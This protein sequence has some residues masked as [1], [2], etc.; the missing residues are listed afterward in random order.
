MQAIFRRALFLL[1]TVLLIL[2]APVVAQG[3]QP[4]HRIVQPVDDLVRVTLH[5]NVHPLAQAAND[6]GAVGDSFPA[7]RIYL[8]LRHSAQQEAALNSYLQEAHTPGSSTYHHWLTPAAFGAQFG[9]NDE[10]I[11]TVTTWLQSKGF[12]VA[13]VNNGKTAIEFSGTAGQLRQAFHTE[14]HSYDV[15]GVMHVANNRDPEIPAALA[16]VVAGLSPLHDFRPTSQL[17]MLGKARY[18]R[19]THTLQPQWTVSGNPPLLM[20]APGDFAVQY[21]LNPL[22]NAGITGTGVTIGLIGA[23]N[24]LPD[25]IAAYRSFFGLPANTFNVIVDGIDPGPSDTVD[26]GNWAEGESIVDVEISG[27]VAPSATINLYTA[28]DTALQSGLLLAAQ[29]AVDDNVAAVLSTSYLECEQSLGLSGNQFFATLWEQAAA[30]GQTPFVSSGDTGSAAC[31]SQDENTATHGLA[32]NG[33]A[34]TPWNI[35]VGGTDFYYTSYAGTTAAQQTELATYWNMTGGSLW[36]PTTTVL[37]PIPEQ[38]WNDPFGLNLETAG[39]Y[40]AGESSIIG[41]GGG[42]SSCTTGTSAADGSFSTCT[43]GYAKPA[44]QSGTGVPADGVRDLPDVSLFAANGANYSSYPI[45]ISAYDCNSSGDYIAISLIGGTS[46]S[47]P[48]MAAIMALVN[49]QYG[50]QGQANYVLYPLAKQQPSAFH[51]VTLGSNNVPCQQGTPSCTLSTLKDNTK[52]DYTLGK[53]YAGTGY[54]LATGLGSVDAYQLVEK[55]NSLS[56][57]PSTTALNL[58]QTTFTHGTPVTVGVSVTGTGGTPSGDVGFLVSE[59]PTLANTLL[60]QLTLSKGSASS[61]VNDLPGG[62][63]QLTARYAGDTT[64]ASST[65]APITLNV[66]PENSTV[67]LTP[68]YWN[69]ATFVATSS[70]AS[71]PYGTFIV[72]DAQPIGVN[73]TKGGTDGI[74]SG[75]LTMTDASSAGSISSGSLSLNSQGLAEWQPS[76]AFSVGANSISASYQGDASFNASTSATPASVTISQATPATL[77]G[78]GPSAITIGSSTTLSMLLDNAAYSSMPDCPNVCT[79]FLSTPLFPTGTVTF[80][81]GTTT[82]GTAPVSGHFATLSNVTSLP[83]GTDTVTASYGGDSNYL[84]ATATTTVNVGLAPTLTAAANPATIN[85]VES[86][87]FTAVVSGSTGLAVPTGYIVFNDTSSTFQDTETLI[88]GKATSKPLFAGGYLPGTE[89]ITVYYSGDATYGPATITTPLTIVSGTTL[90]FSLSASNLSIAPGASTGN[91]STI[92]VTPQ[93]G[94]TGSVYLTCTLTAYPSG[95]A[96]LPGCSIPASVSITGSSAVTASMTISSTAP[97]T[98]QARYNPAPAV[99]PN[100]P[101]QFLFFALTG[102]LFFFRGQRGRKSDLRFVLVFL[103]VIALLFMMSCGGGSSSGGGGQTIPGTTAGSYTFTV[104]AA[105][106]SGGVAQVQSSATV[107]VQ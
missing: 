56:F 34:S 39:V 95:A 42:A 38:P 30:Q 92:T 67:N 102:T 66:A 65:S 80:S 68:R 3:V 87:A 106:T 58:S 61:S 60:P 31:D 14:I 7:E 69:G 29:R 43:A 32:V 64:F 63:Y 15:N 73:A 41:G 49:Q 81:Y 13:R 86:T 45:C 5:G 82:L 59:S 22:Y 88:N 101:A 21:D 36:T 93:G 75:T 90:P 37:K 52:G 74:A 78:A 33:I 9:P 98:T 40:T 27:A 26:R 50:R 89:S 77:L 79:Y 83:L 47:S 4:A 18:N 70:G 44:W 97:S 25:T 96:Y 94:F 57:T 6:R 23:S 19:V 84:P 53:Y 2:P 85:Q 55:W 8:L 11:A 54:D 103:L 16:P 48:S 72:V 100:P 99:K 17:R 12:A 104:Y 28:A 1:F 10:D 46:V 35:A 76:A 107:T 62:T 24:V 20:L 105:L 71:Y 51:D 91:T